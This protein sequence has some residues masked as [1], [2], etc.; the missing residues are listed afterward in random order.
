MPGTLNDS[1]RHAAERRPDAPALLSPHR[2]ALSYRR[3]WEHIQQ[4]TGALRSI[5]I[6][7]ADRVAVVLADGPEMASSFLAISGS[8]VC[9]PL[10]PIYRT[11]EFEFYLGDLSPKALIVEA[12]TDSVAT[13]VARSRGIRVIE[14]VP[15]IGAEAGIF[16]L[17]GIPY[18]QLGV[19]ASRHPDEPSLILHTSGTTSRPKMVPLTHANLYRSAQNISASLQLSTEDRCLSV[20]PMYHIH[21]LV[22]ALL[23]SITVA[24]SIVCTPGFDSSHF[25]DWLEEFQP[26]WLTA[27]PTIYQTILACAVRKP[28]I[29]SHSSLRFIRSCS[30]ALPSSLMAKL[31]QEFQVPVVEAYGMTEASHQVSINPLPPGVRKPGSVGLPVGCVIAVVDDAGAR[32]PAGETGA[33]VIRGPSITRG[34]DNNVEGNQSAFRD[35]WFRTGDEG[36]IDSEG[37][38]FLT[39]RTKEIINRGGEKISPREVEE[40]LLDHPGVAEAMAFAVPDKRLGEDV[41]AV[42]VPV[43][44]QGVG[45]KSQFEIELRDFAANKLASFKVPKRIVFLKEIPKGATGKPQRIGMAAKLGLTE[46]AQAGSVEPYVP[47]ETELQMQIVKIWEEVLDTRPIGIRCDFF[48]LGGDSL[49]AVRMIAEIE[50]VSGI[51]LPVSSLLPAATVENLANAILRTQRED[52]RSPIVAIQQGGSKPPLFFL[53]GQWRG[54]GLYCREL[55]RLLGKDQPFFAVLPHGLD[56][57]HMPLSIEAM[58]ADRVRHLFKDYPEGP[59]RLGGYCNGAL[60]AFEMAQQLRKAGRTVDLLVIVEAHA[61][62]V[63]FRRT[64]SLVGLASALFSVRHKTR[65]EWF[66]RLRTFQ[67]A[68]N[69]AAREGSRRAG[70]FLW[71]KFKRI[72]TLLDKIARNS[73]SAVNVASEATAQS[74]PCAAIDRYVPNSYSSPIALLRTVEIGS[75]TAN[76]S[77]PDDPSAGWAEVAPQIR[78]YWLPGNHESVVRDQVEGLGR[79]LLACLED[80]DSFSD[81]GS[82]SFHKPARQKK[83][84]RPSSEIVQF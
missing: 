79:Q 15:E 31:E 27:V 47:H 52:T 21:G 73:P 68:W 61:P 6:G 57:N 7:P 39:S 11:A 13:G 29:R 63:P 2:D 24:S 41:A 74:D 10:N 44:P 5:G 59:I 16:S 58:A 46:S 23:S 50:A 77:A 42:V 55:S 45:S 48:K 14:L 69:K 51:R 75:R 72:P 84:A 35:G 25:F 80:A 32:L 9:A 54:G 38:L 76:F 66:L 30:S 71:G 70:A 22:G 20:M 8:A 4:V 83:S 1:L 60:V 64:W 62:N 65:T 78:V 36:R 19:T 56:G 17:R 43:E 49:L 40:A 34:Y 33:V 28:G 53:H 26:S 67:N 18:T 37:Y 3:L 81:T 82:T 12:G